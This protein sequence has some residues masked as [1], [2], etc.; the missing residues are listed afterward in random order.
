MSPKRTK[1]YEQA[2]L[3]MSAFVLALSAFGLTVVALIFG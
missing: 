2:E 3:G 1:Q